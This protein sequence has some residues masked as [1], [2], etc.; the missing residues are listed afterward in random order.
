MLRLTIRSADELP[1]DRS[2]DAWPAREQ[3][4]EST[5][6]EPSKSATRAR[7]A[8]MD[9]KRKEKPGCAESRA[10][11][12]AAE[13]GV[14]LRDGQCGFSIAIH[15]HLDRNLELDLAWDWAPA[16]T[17]TIRNKIIIKS[18][19]YFIRAAAP[20]RG[21]SAPHGAPGKG[22]TRRRPARKCQT[23]TAGTRR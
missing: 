5:K 4:R 15:L 9:W 19:G 10:F 21:P 22:R 11:I 17:I 3:A 23:P 8:R 13:S 20:R 7:W 14:R 16:R 2:A 18:R 1:R 6:A 12:I